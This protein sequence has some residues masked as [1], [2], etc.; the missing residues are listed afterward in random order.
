MWL[1]RIDNNCFSYLFINCFKVCGWF[2]VIFVHGFM[3][4]GRW[5]R[6]K[7]YIS[8]ISAAS[9]RHKQRTVGNGYWWNAKVYAF[10][11]LCILHT[12]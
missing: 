2:K 4:S 10:K 7:G 8:G 12:N 3:Y 5:G 11:K 6:S 1:C 9:T